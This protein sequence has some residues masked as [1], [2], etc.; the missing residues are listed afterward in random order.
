MRTR[1]VICLVLL[2]C[3]RML[4]AADDIE[5]QRDIRPILSNSCFHC[6]GP[7]E[8]HREANL[9]LDTRDGLFRDEGGVV[10]VDVA[11]PAKSELLRRLFADD[12]SELMPPPESERSL[13][14]EQKVLLRRWIESGAK[15]SQHWSFESPQRPSV[16][17]LPDASDIPNPID[18]FVRV[19]LSRSR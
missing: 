9:R 5:F 4:I 19:S 2:C 18:A 1:F 14:K 10:I 3:S 6:H 11:R 17:K 7:D 12:E 13:T 8:E 15:Y 16:P